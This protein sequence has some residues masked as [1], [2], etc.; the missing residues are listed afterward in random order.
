[1]KKTIVTALVAATVLT[2]ATMYVVT[3]VQPERYELHIVQ[4]GE[5]MTSI[6][7]NANRNSDVNYNIRDAI[8]I[9]VSKS[10]E[11]KGGAVSRQLQVGDKV[12]VPIYR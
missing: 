11:M 10:S 5:T 3:P 9:A 4:Y 8:S 2:G 7:E 12:A 1:M 6:I